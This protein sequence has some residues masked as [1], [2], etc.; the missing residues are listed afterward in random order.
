MIHENYIG[1]TLNVK[2]EIKKM[3]NISYSANTLSDTDILDAT[4]NFDL[5]TYV[6]FNTVKATAKCNKKGH[7]KF[8]QFL[9][10]IS[11]TNKNKREKL[12]YNKVKFSKLEL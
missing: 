6:A 4:F 5:Q 7:M 11:T 9:G 2:D 1:S 10:R 3:E 12:D 8:S